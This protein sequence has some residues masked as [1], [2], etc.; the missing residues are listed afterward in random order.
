MRQTPERAA[1]RKAARLIAKRCR[2]VIQGLLRD[3]EK[4][5]CDRE[6]MRIA[7]RVIRELPAFKPQGR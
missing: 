2:R 5:E 7:E 4:G 6:F 3:E 1:I